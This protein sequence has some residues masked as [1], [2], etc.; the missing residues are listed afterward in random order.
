MNSN[1]GQVS[2]D[3]LLHLLKKYAIVLIIFEI[4]N[5]FGIGYI[6]RFYHWIFPINNPSTNLNTQNFHLTV[7]IIVCCNFIIGLFLLSDLNIRKSLSW[8]LFVLTLFAPWIG[9][10]F[11]MFWKVIE[12]K[13]GSRHP[14]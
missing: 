4:I 5:R 13:N 11:L 7:A 10:I 9:V 2:S 12:M 1:I 6:I 3:N 14:E 8:M